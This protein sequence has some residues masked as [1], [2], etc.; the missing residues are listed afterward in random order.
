LLDPNII[1]YVIYYSKHDPVSK[2]IY[3][4]IK[5]DFKVTTPKTVTGKPIYTSQN[6]PIVVDYIPESEV[7][8]PEMGRIGLCMAPGR[9]KKKKNHDWQRS[10]DIDL[11]RIKDFYHCDVLVSLVTKSELRDIH[12]PFLFEHV[13][14]KGMESIHFPIKDKWIPQSM[15]KLMELVELIISRLKERKTVVVHCNGGKGRSGTI[16]VATLVG[17]GHKVDNAIKVV[18]SSR[19]GT[20]KNPVQIA[21]LKRFKKA[22]KKKKKTQSLNI[23]SLIIQD[24]NDGSEDEKLMPGEK[25]AIEN[26]LSSK[27]LNTGEEPEREASPERSTISEDVSG[28]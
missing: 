17:L 13:V 16:V 24:D 8:L 19:S 12:T 28:Q 9:T 10:L 22:W 2:R 6:F 20:I 25:E 3:R 21:Y 5:R 1:Y 7:Y 18:R 26:Y 11:E 23:D 27:N 15:L 14:E 4:K